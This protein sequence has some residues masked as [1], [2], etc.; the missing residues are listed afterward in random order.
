M[1]CWGVLYHYMMKHCAM[2]SQHKL[3]A[4]MAHSTSSDDTFCSAA[5]QKITLMSDL[6][7]KKEEV[8]YYDSMLEQNPNNPNTWLL[9]TAAHNFAG[10][11]EA[12]LEVALK[13]IQKFP[14]YATLYSYA[15]NILQE[16]GRHDE[17]FP[18]WEKALALKPTLLAAAYSICFCHEELEQY[19]EACQAWEDLSRTLTQLGYT[20]E[21]EEPRRKAE[22]CR[23]KIGT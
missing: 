15:G 12:A 14:D 1:R 8:N 18:Y 16:L 2:M 11:N 3:E 10:D 4:A 20:I 9:C 22:A 21:A 23:A 13:G 7:R 17:A 19:T 5:Q 6:G